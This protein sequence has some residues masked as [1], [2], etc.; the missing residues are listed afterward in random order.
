[1]SLFD[2][3]PD[4]GSENA[5]V[6]AFQMPPPSFAKHHDSKLPAASIIGETVRKNCNSSAA[7]DLLRDDHLVLLAIDA[8]LALHAS[9]KRWQNRR[10][11]LQALADLDERQ[12]RDIGLTRDEL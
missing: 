3:R 7:R 8:V 5:N 6:N 4:G 11:T 2:I 10:R 12:L 1:L 9:V